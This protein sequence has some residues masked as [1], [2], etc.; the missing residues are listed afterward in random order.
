MVDFCF[1]CV[2][3]PCPP[4]SALP[5]P[6]SLCNHLEEYRGLF[7]AN[8]VLRGE[9]LGAF[10]NAN[11]WHVLGA[12]VTPRFPSTHFISNCLP[13]SCPSLYTQLT[14]NSLG[15]DIKHF[16]FQPSV[17]SPSIVRADK[18]PAD[19]DRRNRT[20]VRE[21]NAT[22]LQN[23][24]VVILS[25][26]EQC[27]NDHKHLYRF[28]QA[29]KDRWIN[30]STLTID[31]SIHEPKIDLLPAEQ[32]GQ[33]FHIT[34][35]FTGANPRVPSNPCVVPWV[36]PTLDPEIQYEPKRHLLSPLKLLTDI[37]SISMLRTW[38]IFHT[39]QK[40]DPADPT[41]ETI[42]EDEGMSYFYM[43][44]EYGSVEE[45]LE[46][47]G[48]DLKTWSG[49]GL[50]QAEISEYNI[51]EPVEDTGMVEGAFRIL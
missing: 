27:N 49:L 42:L 5:D 6:E 37:Q 20:A 21:W 30:P 26:I 47:A 3:E 23:P 4:I 41:G 24:A 32:C 11:V 46:H 33:T 51:I 31:Y 39:W 8:N 16:I 29:Q 13:Y 25:E 43:Q 1:L 2:S 48:P 22:Q 36:A 28:A 12:N 34:I 45:M 14:I 40:A 38:S 10:S 44:H 9:A 35:K 17:A 18:L 50:D 7:E 19:L 15:M